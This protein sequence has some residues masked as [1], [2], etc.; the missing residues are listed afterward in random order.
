MLVNKE[1]QLAKANCSIQGISPRGS[2]ENIMLLAV[3]TDY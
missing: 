2:G 1:E 3:L